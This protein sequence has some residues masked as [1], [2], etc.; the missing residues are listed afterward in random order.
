MI[1]NIYKYLHQQDHATG[2]P[3]PAILPPI[4][5]WFPPRLWMSDVSVTLALIALALP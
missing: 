4:S 1:V 5:T 2:N 3:S